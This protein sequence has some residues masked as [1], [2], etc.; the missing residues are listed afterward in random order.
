ME[1]SLEADIEL[2]HRSDSPFT[3]RR[4]TNSLGARLTDYDALVERNRRVI[5]FE[6]ASRRDITNL[7]NWVDGNGCIARE[8]T[9][10][11]AQTEDLLSVAVTDDSA[12]TW[13]GALVEDGR[14]Y[15]REHFSKN[16]RFSISRDPNVH[17]F[18]PA[19]TTQAARLCSRCNIYNSFNRF[20]F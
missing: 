13:I 3:P 1:D 2:G 5:G 8:E 6:A 19:S 16:S 14:V 10:Y 11:L 4:D 12:M 9:A 17:I 20:Y 18:P 15:F 7:R